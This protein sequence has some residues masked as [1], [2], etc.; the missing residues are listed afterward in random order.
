MTQALS[1]NITFKDAYS[2]TTLNISIDLAQDYWIY[3]V[4]CNILLYDLSMKP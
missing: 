3:R 1:Q 4:L 2:M